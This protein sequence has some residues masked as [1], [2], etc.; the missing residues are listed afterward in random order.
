M[1]NIT[2][3][4]IANLVKLIPSHGALIQTLRHHPSIDFES[5]ELVGDS[6]EF[7]DPRV[8]VSSFDK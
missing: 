3:E 8:S 1:Q 4:D 6:L 2:I 7:D 5:V